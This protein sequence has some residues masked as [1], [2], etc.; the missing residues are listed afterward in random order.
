MYEKQVT[1]L[2]RE[3]SFSQLFAN[4]VK[5][6]GMLGLH[7]SGGETELVYLLSELHLAQVPPML[8][9]VPQERLGTSLCTI[10]C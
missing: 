6:W 5:V 4:E 2:S 9:C 3:L 1:L 7:G 10:R 8:T